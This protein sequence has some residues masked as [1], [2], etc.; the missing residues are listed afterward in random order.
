MD[1]KTEPFVNLTVDE[2]NE[3]QTPFAPDDNS[4]GTVPVGKQGELKKP[5]S[6]ENKFIF[7]L[8]SCIAAL[9]VLALIIMLIFIMNRPNTG[10]NDKASSRTKNA[11]TASANAGDSE[12][13]PVRVSPGVVEN[14]AY[15]EAAYNAQELANAV[16]NAQVIPASEDEMLPEEKAV[17]NDTTTQKAATKTTTKATT[18]KTTPAQTT[19][20]AQDDPTAAYAVDGVDEDVATANLKRAGYIVRSV[21]VCDS[22][23]VTGSKAA[24]KSGLVLSHDLYTGPTTG[25]RFAMIR[26]ATSAPYSTARKVPNVMGKQWKNARAT[27]RNHGLGIRFLFDTGMG[28]PKG[29]VISQSAAAGAYM[30]RG[31]TVVVVLAD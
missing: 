10:S 18:K 2:P 28:K 29:T 14:A 11:K 12:I 6:K 27:L 23:A 9:T 20:V 15:D 4:Q 7:V 5:R 21:Y 1:D 17:V 19:T 26:V 24:P 25:Q 3:L 31:C 30:A 16:A 22:G 13:E 8:V